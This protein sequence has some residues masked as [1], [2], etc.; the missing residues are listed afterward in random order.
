MAAFETMVVTTAGFLRK[1]WLREVLGAVTLEEAT[2]LGALF[3][4]EEE[5]WAAARAARE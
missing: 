1:C 5:F 4:I 2:D 3:F